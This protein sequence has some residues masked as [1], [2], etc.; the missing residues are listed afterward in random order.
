MID[1]EEKIGRQ[2]HAIPIG[3]SGGEI[4]EL[5]GPKRIGFFDV[6]EH[7]SKAS[8]RTDVADADREANQELTE[9][10]GLA[11]LKVLEVAANGN[12]PRTRLDGLANLE[13]RRC[14]AGSKLRD[15]ERQ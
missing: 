3:D 5:N 1:D 11:D 7:Q 12:H 4:A 6:A 13:R 8:K 9:R 14:F 15:L 2:I 10:E